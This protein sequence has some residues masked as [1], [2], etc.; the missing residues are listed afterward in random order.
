[1]V[2][3]KMCI[4]GETTQL[5]A[6]LDSAFVAEPLTRPGRMPMASTWSPIKCGSFRKCWSLASFS[7]LLCMLRVAAADLPWANWRGPSATGVSLDAQPAV[8]WSETKNIA[9]K[10]PAPGGGHSSPVI[11][12]GR[13][14]LSAEVPIGK[15]VTPVFDEAPGSHDNVGVDRSHEFFVTALDLASGKSL[16]RTVVG[17]SFTAGAASAAVAR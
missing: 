14:F 10:V 6:G 7:F 9:W 8:E 16:W 12:D 5:T 15:A 13:I 3:G 2:H 4:E 1:M 17:R 11:A